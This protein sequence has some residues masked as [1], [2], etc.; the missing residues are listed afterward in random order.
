MKLKP[1]ILLTGGAGYIGGHIARELLDSGRRLVILDD[2]STGDIRTV[3]SEAVFYKNEIGD[4]SSLERIFTDH[5]IESVIHLAAVASVPESVMDPVRCNK[6][7]HLDSALLMDASQSHGVSNF[8]FSSTSVVY[9][10]TY[11]PPFSEESALAPLSP[12]AQTKLAAERHLSSKD[13]MRYAVLRYFNVGGADIRIGNRK[14]ND[15]TL[16]KSALECASGKRDYLEIYGTDYPTPDGTCIRDYI[17][18]SDIASAHVLSLDYLQA[19][20]Q[21]ETFNLGLQKGF[22]VREVIDVAKSVTRIDFETRDAP[23][24]EGDP[25]HIFADATKAHRVLGFKPKATTL[26]EIIADSWSWELFERDSL[27]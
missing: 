12:Y 15:M 20:G 26:T 19:G 3:P 5:N 21:S 22:S 13:E 4:I 24:R 17:H 7:N 27:K 25:A 14:R 23:R 11:P 10:E 16:I 9:D 1:T 2:L 8:I 18:V 6:I